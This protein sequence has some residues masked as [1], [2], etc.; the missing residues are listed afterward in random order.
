MPASVQYFSRNV[1]SCSGTKKLIFT[2]QKA[3][4]SGSKL[5]PIENCL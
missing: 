3:C 4:L 1:K 5:M 2:L